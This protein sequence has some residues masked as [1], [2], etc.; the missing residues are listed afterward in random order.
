M[1]P[2]I[3]VKHEFTQVDCEPTYGTALVSRMVLRNTLGVASKWT[4]FA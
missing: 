2:N 1:N 3:G 4:L